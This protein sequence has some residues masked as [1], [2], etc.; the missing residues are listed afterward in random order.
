M[1]VPNR[2]TRRPPRPPLLWWS[3]AGVELV[4]GLFFAIAV[5]GVV[6]LRII[7][8]L[9]AALGVALGAWRASYDARR[10]AAVQRSRSC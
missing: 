6:L 3:V 1:Q 7:L 2:W 10:L 4:L 9:L 5:P 8:V